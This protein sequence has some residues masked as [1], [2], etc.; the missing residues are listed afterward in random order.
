MPQTRIRTRE[1][2]NVP[3]LPE[4]EVIRRG[5]APLICRKEF[6][7]PELLFSGAIRHPSPEQFSRDLAGRRVE[8]IA[9]TGKYLRIELDRGELVVHLRMTG[10]LVYRENGSSAEPYLRAILPFTD[11]TALFFS[12]MRKFG[13]L[14]LLEGEDE[15]Q[16]AGL[17]RLGPDIFEQVGP[18]LFLEMIR[19][20]PRVR[21][22]ALLLD[23]RFAAGM[24][25]I[26]VDESLFRAGIHPQREAGSLS[27][28]EVLVLY[29]AVRSAL[30][31]G[32]DCG[33]TSSRDYR[34]ALGE[35]GAF[36]H[37]LAVYGRKG[38]P[39]PRC[40]TPVT[41]IVVAGRG[42]YLCARCQM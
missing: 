14:W 39:C 8:N 26:Y 5:L 40:G 23:Q 41:R 34:D 37:R 24:G 36:Q 29:R 7:S 31:E 9:R 19:G 4:V 21:I 28:E 3:E 18:E 12:D 17:H 16:R 38:R 30:Q 13:G 42:T 15:Q 10:R 27:R 11:G 1:V 22:K 25:N 35:Q 6:G 20:R 2:K 33:G 32:I